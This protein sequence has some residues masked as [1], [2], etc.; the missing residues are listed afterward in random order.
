MHELYNKLIKLLKLDSRLVSD[1]KLLR[2]KVVELAYK[3]DKDLLKS[4]MSDKEFKDLFFIDVEDAL[5]FDQIKFQ[6]FISNKEF[7]PDSYT[8]FKNKIGLTSDTN[9]LSEVNDVVLSFPYK[10]CVLEG[11]QDKEDAKRDEVFY[12][13][14]LAHG[15]IDRILEPKVFTGFKNFEDDKVSDV[16]SFNSTDNLVIKGNNILALK[17]LE[18]T[19]KNKVKL[20]YIDPPYNTDDDSFAYNDSFKHS[21]WL[22]FMKNRLEIARNLLSE[23]GFIFIQ[24]ND[25]EQAYL[26][27]LCDEIFK[28]ENFHTTICVQM[29]YLSGV[30]MAHKEKKL[31]KIKEYVLM[32]TKSSNIKLNPQYA[33]SDWESALDRYTSFINKKGLSDDQCSEWEITTVNKA[34]EK[35]GIDKNDNNTVEQFKLEHADLIFRTARNRGADYSDL[36]SD[37]FSKIDNDDDTYY[38]VYKGEDVAFASDKVEKIDGKLVPV[39]ALGDIWTD[40]GINNLSNEGGVDLRFGKKPEKLLER[41]ISLTTEEKDIVLD[42]FAG[43]GTTGAV[44]HKMNRRYILVEQLDSHFKKTIKRLQNVVNGES[45]GVSKKYDWQGGGSFKS[46]EL[47]ESNNKYIELIAESDNPTKALEDIRNNGFI[48]HKVDLDKLT[49]DEFSKL[50]KKEQKKLLLEILDKN[51]L[52]VNLEDID[53]E[54]FGISDEVKRLNK[55]FYGI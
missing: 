26:K 51:H 44:A 29:S 16:K 22:T 45:S 34:M 39:V 28:P 9:Y 35:A 38:F 4:L 31:P 10:D 30:K 52:Y 37:V 46:L 25:I 1:D 33:P 12:N 19:H 8:A 3:L 24:I 14:M 5:V 40:I 2:N 50:S 54:R 55:Q 48:T 13:E 7:L 43:S 23:D 41:I 49:E 42:F 18:K 47:Y 53:D 17:S 21:T 27:V 32:Y 36:P 20:I 15:E 11:G 6:K